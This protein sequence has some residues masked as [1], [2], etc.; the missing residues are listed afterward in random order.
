MEKEFDTLA[1]LSVTSGRLLTKRVGKSD[2]GISKIYELL[3]WMSGESV[4]T[5]EIPQYM[6]KFSPQIIQQHPY[7]A[8]LTPY[9]VSMCEQGVAEKLQDELINMFGP[10]ISL[11]KTAEVINDE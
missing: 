4:W 7:F 8:E 3:G 2:N 1:V 10:A 11:K 5:H 9:I 6:N